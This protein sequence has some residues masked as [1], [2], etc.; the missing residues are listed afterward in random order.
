MEKVINDYKIE[1]IAL[2]P[3]YLTDDDLKSLKNQG[4]RVHWMREDEDGDKNIF[5]ITVDKNSMKCC[6]HCKICER[7]MMC[8]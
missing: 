6:F 7:R 5:M 4:F 1:E 8:Q 2:N 3:T